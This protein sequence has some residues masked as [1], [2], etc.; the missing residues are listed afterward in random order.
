MGTNKEPSVL[1][2]L[3]NFIVRFLAK[4]H[5]FWYN[6]RQLFEHYAEILTQESGKNFVNIYCTIKL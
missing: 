3:T 1:L 6:Q 4:R 2:R 5:I